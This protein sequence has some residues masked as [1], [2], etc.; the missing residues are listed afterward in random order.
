M[1]TTPVFFMAIERA[2]GEQLE[3]I[4]TKWVIRTNVPELREASSSVYQRLTLLP[5]KMDGGSIRAG[6]VAILIA[7]YIPVWTFGAR[8]THGPFF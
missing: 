4:S 2:E 7:I 5:A 1:S 6:E 8:V 3:F